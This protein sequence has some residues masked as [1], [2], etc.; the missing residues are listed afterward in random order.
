MDSYTRLEKVLIH[1]QN[2]QRISQRLG[3]LLMKEG[4]QELGKNLIANAQLHDNSKLRGIEFDHLFAGDELLSVTVS[5]HQKTN[6]H[7]PEYW[8][9][10]QNMPEVFFAE[11][12]CDWAARG[13]EFGSNVREWITNSA[14]EKYN[15][16]MTDTVGIQV[17]RFLDLILEKPF[18]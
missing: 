6:P 7:H 3:I 2:V 11:M 16:E 10:I 18:K 5:H 1:I 12:V 8:G 13:G 15:F 14:T 17:N 4:E 9:G